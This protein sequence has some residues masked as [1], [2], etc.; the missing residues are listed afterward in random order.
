MLPG[1]A[2]LVVAGALWM[3]PRGG[4]SKPKGMPQPPIKEVP[5]TKKG[6]TGTQFHEPEKAESKRVQVPMQAGGQQERKQMTSSDIK[7]PE[8]NM[9]K[10]VSR[11]PRLRSPLSS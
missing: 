7:T 10:A 8:V 3:L 2:L 5:E 9:N 6:S 1:V 11:L 4:S